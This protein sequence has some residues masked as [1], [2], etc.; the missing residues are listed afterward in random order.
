MALA[1]ACL[2]CGRLVRGASRCPPCQRDRD[3]ARGSRQARGY[4][5]THDRLRGQLVAALDPAAPCPRCTRPLGG[6]AALLDLMHNEDRSGW[7]GLGHSSCNRDVSPMGE[8]RRTPR[9]PNFASHSP[10]P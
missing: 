10:P 3:R 4:D 9:K 6:E 7:L 2:G 1:R 8:R 5:A